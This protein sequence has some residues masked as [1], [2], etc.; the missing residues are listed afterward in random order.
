MTDQKR[1][2]KEDEGSTLRNVAVGAAN[3]ETVG[4]FGSANAEYIKGYTGVD[5]ET[6]QK[7]AKGLK[8]ISEGKADHP[9]H[10]QNNIKQQAGYSAEVATTSRDNAEAIIKKLPKRTMR[11]DD[12]PQ[13]GKN[14]QVVDRVQVL[15]G[16]IIAG[17]ESQMKFVSDYEKLLN[18][19]FEEGKNGNHKY[20]KYRNVKLELPSEQVKEAREYC[21]KQAENFRQQAEGAARDGKPPEVVNKLRGNA[22]RFQ[23]AA[24]SAQIVDSGLTTEQAIFYREHPELATAMD[25]AATS[26]RA[27]LKGAGCGAAIGGA[28]SIVTNVIAVCQD[29]K[30]LK[31]A[32]LDTAIGTGKAAAVGYG[33]AFAGSAVKGV[34]QQS[35]STVARTL[36]RTSLPALTVSVCLELGSAVTRYARGEID[37]VEFLE[38]IGERGSGMLAGGLGATL[39]QI[40]IPIPVVGGLIG[41]MVGYTLSSMLYRDSLAAFREAKAAHA[42]YLRIKAF[43]EEARASMEA[44]RLQFRARF[45]EW[46]EEGRAE[47]ADCVSRMDIA[48]ES[49]QL[50]EFAVAAD[51]L[52]ACMGRSL[53]FADR[54]ALDRFMGT[55]K[56]LAF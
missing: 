47:L 54:E 51:A 33:T 52:A 48:A 43:C 7:F 46:L 36:S 32:L 35:S 34:M 29:D 19:I 21:R 23:Q 17:S 30:E 25:M 22:E 14:H 9:I 5:N 26:H 53:Q 56:G 4:R 20:A 11:G 41:G 38:T 37:G 2:K 1:E 50:D 13:Y 42:D 40:G 6:G 15:D 8:G 16:K 31:E 28:I 24:D 18:D 3:I 49:G 39:G 10:A 12:H 44:Y 45:S 27:G 55:D